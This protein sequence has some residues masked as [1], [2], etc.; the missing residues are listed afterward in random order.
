MQPE[1]TELAEFVGRHHPRSEHSRVR[2]VLAGRKLMRV[3]LEIADAAIIVA[4]IA[5]NVAHRLRLGN[6]APRL[7][8]DD[9]EFA[10][11]VEVSRD[12]RPHDRLQ[13]S[14]LAVR[15]A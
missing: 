5:G 13:M 4:G 1:L 11:I 6:V 2:E 14:G 8:D 3:T 9:R 10:F 12:P 7:A 15:V